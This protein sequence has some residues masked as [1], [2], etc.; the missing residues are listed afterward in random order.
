[1]RRAIGLLWIGLLAMG[2][3]LPDVVP[4]PTMTPIE[5]TPT[6]AP[7]STDVPTPTGVPT[8]TEVPTSTPWPT[9][10]QVVAPDGPNLLANPAFEGAFTQR[11]P[12][13]ASLTVAEGWEPFYCAPPYTD[14]A[15]PAERIGDGNPA[16]LEMGIPEYKPTDLENR[17]VSGFAQQWYCFFRACRAGVYQVVETRPGAVCEAGVWVQTWSAGSWIGDD[18]PY[19]SFYQSE[20][21]RANSTWR[22]GVDPTGRTDAFAGSVAWGAVADYSDGHFDHYALVSERFIAGGAQT[23]IFIENLRLWPFA[24]NDSYVDDAYLRCSE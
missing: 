16:G 18:G 9:P 21:E 10:T 15:C 22:I 13:S 4:T 14:E 6:D 11:E 1:M 3:T 8:S 24:H 12:L 17:V 5:E 2:C 7:T 20:D 23:T 19:T